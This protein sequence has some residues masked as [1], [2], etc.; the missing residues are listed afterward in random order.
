MDEVRK[1]WSRQRYF[2]APGGLKFIFITLCSRRDETR[3][4]Y[5]HLHKS[6]PFSA[7]SKL[8]PLSDQKTDDIPQCAINC[9]MPIKE[10]LVSKEVTIPI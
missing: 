9:S 7:P 1:R 4:L 8:V 6:R 2:A 5:S 10:A 3:L